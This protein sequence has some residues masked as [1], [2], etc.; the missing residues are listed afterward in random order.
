MKKPP[1]FYPPADTKKQWF[2]EGNYEMP[3]VTKLLLHT[4]ETTGWPGYAGGGTAPTLTYNPWTHEWRQHFPLYGSARALRDPSNTEVRENRDNV[5]QVEIIAYCDPASAKKYGH[6]VADLD[7]KALEDLADFVRFLHENA[8]LPL[9]SAPVWLPYPASYGNSPVRMT[10][11]KYDA[12]HGV[13][14]HQHASG[15]SHGDPGALN[16]ERIMQLASGQ[17]VKSV[18]TKPKP[19]PPPFPGHD[20]FGFGKV[21][22]YVTMLGKQL[23]KKGYGGHYRFGPGPVWTSSDRKAVRAFQLAQGWTG[24]DADGLP[25]PLTW[26]RLFS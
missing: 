24:E 20:K 21:N 17:Q 2:G 4:T 15:N 14:G 7:D 22:K 25:G 13:L 16:V 3:G 12:F 6:F 19:I 11:A 1:K 5:V 23:K 18:T 10:S 9:R 8:D 26:R